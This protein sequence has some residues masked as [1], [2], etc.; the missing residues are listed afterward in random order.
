IVVDE[1]L[2]WSHE[3]TKSAALYALG[4]LSSA[5]V[6]KPETTSAIRKLVQ[7]EHPMLSETA[8]WYIDSVVAQ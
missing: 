5:Q 8:Q 3:F 1:R 7:H 4:L 6:D 2:I